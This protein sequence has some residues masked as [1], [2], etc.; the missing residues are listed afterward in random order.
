MLNI[1]EGNLV[2]L[3]IPVGTMTLAEQTRNV[4]FNGNLNASG[5]VGTTGSI[6]ESRVFYTDALGTPG[7]EVTGAT[8][9]NTPIFV[10]DGAGGFVQAFDGSATSITV[11][12]VEKGGK[13]LGTAVFDIEAGTTFDDYISFLDEYMGNCGDI[14]DNMCC[15][16]APE[17]RSS[18]SELIKMLSKMASS[19]LKRKRS[20]VPR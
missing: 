15:V 2:D 1:V 5:E 7:T 13:D 10:S 3:N 17:K 12:G 19:K 20:L 16:G 8:N 6:H 9:L 14:V 4:V 18:A 11:S